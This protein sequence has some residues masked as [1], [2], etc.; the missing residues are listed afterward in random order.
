MASSRKRRNGRGQSPEL[1]IQ[2]CTNHTNDECTTPQN[3]VGAKRTCVQTMIASTAESASFMTTTTDARAITCFTKTSAAAKVDKNVRPEDSFDAL[4]NVFDGSLCSHPLLTGPDDTSISNTNRHH[5]MSDD[6]SWRPI[7]WSHRVAA[8][9]A[10]ID[11][12]DSDSDYT[13]HSNK[14]RILHARDGQPPPTKRCKGSSS[15]EPSHDPIGIVGSDSPQMRAIDNILQSVRRYYSPKMYQEKVMPILADCS[16]RHERRERKFL[17][18]PGA[19][20]EA[21]VELLGG[22]TFSQLYRESQ[23]TRAVESVVT[24]DP[25]NTMGPWIVG[26]RLSFRQS[27]SGST[28]GIQHLVEDGTEAI[29]KL[30][31]DEEMAAWNHMLSELPVSN[32]YSPVATFACNSSECLEMKL[33]Q[34]QN[35]PSSLEVLPASYLELPHANRT[36]EDGAMFRGVP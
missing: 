2:M 11:G 19:I 17:H 21:L 29:N 20:F 35:Q 23:Q 26:Y 25:I 9:G 18:L 22:T 33:P 6:E 36:V 8:T 27:G 24:A 15:S 16:K 34:T 1:L 28:T 5:T 14:S 12:D 4:W 7:P 32:D 3:I 10:A 30:R 13:H 31:E